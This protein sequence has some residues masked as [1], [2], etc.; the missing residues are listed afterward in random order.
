VL[1]NQQREAYTQD[2]WTVIPNILGEEFMSVEAE[3]SKL[4]PAVEEYWRN[5]NQYPELRGGQFDSVRTIPT[6]NPVLD[7][8][9]FA[10]TFRS[11]AKQVTGT[12]DLQLM[13][14]GYQAKF[15][16]AADFD[17]ILHRDYGNHTLVVPHDGPQSTMVG[18][19]VYFTNVTAGDGPTM[20]VRRDRVE[21][22][23]IAQTH[24]ERAQWPEIYALEEP[25][26][27]DAGSLLVY[28]YRTFHRG[29]SL[30]AP[31]AHRLSF[32]FAYGTKA[33]WHGFYSW[34][35]RAEEDEVRS[36]VANL[37]A[38]ERELIGFPPVG[39]AYWTAETVQAVSCRYPGA[40]MSSYLE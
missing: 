38:R 36:M 29:S 22:I 24:L 11:I 7:R 33:P 2:G 9:A 30:T 12:D 37:D 39:D 34:P 20:A 31:H 6:G 23:N 27:C 26:L 13:R 8:L 40:D 16:G 28:D 3:A 14:G 10:E 21:H 19:F 5:P 25:I 18:F 15:A 4:F 32:S 1:N 35:N 17:Q